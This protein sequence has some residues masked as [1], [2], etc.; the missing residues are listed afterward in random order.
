M[1]RTRR[2]PITG[3]GAGRS[4]FIH[5][6]DAVDATVRAVERG[7]SGI[8]NVCDDEPVEQR[9]WLPELARMLGAKR[10]F[11]APAWLVGRL[12]GPTVRF[13]GTSLRGA[14]N[15]KAK[16]ALGIAPRPWRAGF[17]AEFARS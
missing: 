17:E 4:S 5:I 11:R 12:G 13:Y 1:V 10:P 16:R 3:S 9:V 14:S 15:S 8:Y 2:L 6:D 7:E